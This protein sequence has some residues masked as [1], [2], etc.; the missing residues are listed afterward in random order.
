MM[1]DGQRQRPAETLQAGD[2]VRLSGGYDWEPRWLSGR[3][4]VDGHV[5]GFV[6]GQND[7]PAALVKLDEPITVD[8]V[9]GS[10]VVLELRFAGT[11]WSGRGTVH[12]ELCDFDPEPVRWQD[13]DR[14]KWVESHATYERLPGS[15]PE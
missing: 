15:T 1:T 7:R 3:S 10:V 8:G 14:G 11:R 12:V 13:R 4:Q 9:T 5:A 6:P 2:R